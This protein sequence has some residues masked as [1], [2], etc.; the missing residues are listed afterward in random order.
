MVTLVGRHLGGG[1]G[2]ATARHEPHL[3][4]AP[5]HPRSRPTGYRPRSPGCP[6]RRRLCAWPSPT[7]G[8]SSPPPTRR[9]VRR[10]GRSPTSTGPSPS[11]PSPVRRP[12]SAWP[13]TR[14]QR[15]DVDR[16]RG[17]PGRD[18][19]GHPRG[20]TG[21]SISCVSTTFCVAGDEQGDVHTTTD[22]T[23]G[24]S[25]WSDHDT[26]T[27][28]ARSVSM[29]CPE[30]TL[31]VA[32]DEATGTCSSRPTRPTGPGRPRHIDAVDPV[33][34]MSCTVAPL[35]VGTDL[36]GDV[37]TTDDPTGP[38]PATGWSPRSTP[39]RVPVCSWNR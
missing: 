4:G 6:A 28:Q 34:S 36:N 27:R 24:P 21:L 8:T 14:G 12:A 7:T 2:G 19:D 11:V 17:R 38:R 30:T 37:L 29:S 35:C 39:P 31:C 26:S 5:H 9:T 33:T 23:G 13:S 22:P 18:V 1:P 25:A 20:W 32:G 10:R 3:V 16:T 15:P